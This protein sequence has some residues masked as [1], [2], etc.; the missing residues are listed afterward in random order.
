MYSDVQVD[1]YPPAKKKKKKWRRS[2]SNENEPNATAGEED[3]KLQNPFKMKRLSDK[4]Q[5]SA[6]PRNPS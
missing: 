3:L 6:S 4:T 5:N 2:E 1:L